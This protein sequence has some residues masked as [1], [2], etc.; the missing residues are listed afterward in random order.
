MF[1]LIL[2]FLTI[3]S[4]PFTELEQ[5]LGILPDSHPDLQQPTTSTAANNDDTN[6]NNTEESRASLLLKV[7]FLEE[8]YGLRN[9]KKNSK[10][11]NDEAAASNAPKG[12]SKNERNDRFFS[13]EEIDEIIHVLRTQSNTKE[14]KHVKFYQW[15][16]AYYVSESEPPQ[17]LK[18]VKPPKEVEGEDEEQK[19]IRHSKVKSAVPLVVVPIEDMFDRCLEIHNRVGKHG[20]ESSN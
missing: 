19:K 8:L 2:S 11:A 6:T 4:S 12:E 18:K 1:A 14:K 3:L 9:N 17:L 15:D 10:A 7:K 16:N 13:K 20:R 5:Q